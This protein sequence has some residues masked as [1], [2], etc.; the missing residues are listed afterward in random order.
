MNDGASGGRWT[1][2]ILVSAPLLEGPSAEE[3]QGGKQSDD[4]GDSP[5]GTKRSCFLF[6]TVKVAATVAPP[7]V[8][9]RSVGVDRA[10]LLMVVPVD[11]KATLLPALYGPDGPS[12][13]GGNLLPGVE[14]AVRRWLG[15]GRF[16][17]ACPL[18]HIAGPPDARSGRWQSFYPNSA[19]PQAE[20]RD[21]GPM[22]HLFACQEGQSPPMLAL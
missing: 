12:E 22:S 3:K 16:R 9:L 8:D 10:P 11:G 21:I 19:D 20:K 7:G 1:A 5:A 15:G 2:S 17:P 18:Y 14:P 6:F 4:C 13:V